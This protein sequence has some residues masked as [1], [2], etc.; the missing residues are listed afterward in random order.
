MC[1]DFCV[2]CLVMSHAHFVFLRFGV[3]FD[4]LSSSY[5][6]FLHFP[7]TFVHVCHTFSVTLILCLDTLHSS[8][9]WASILHVLLMLNTQIMLHQYIPLWM[10]P[11]CNTN[12]SWHGE[13][14]DG[15]A[16]YLTLHMLHLTTKPYS[17]QNG[18]S[19]HID[20]C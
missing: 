18:E 20:T 6:L 12:V 17:S 16:S 10:R 3:S 7:C 2:L 14:V 5:C 11:F 8:S 15:H 9:H 13:N 4:S 1:H 19:V